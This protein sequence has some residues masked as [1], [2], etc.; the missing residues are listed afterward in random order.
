MKLFEIRVP[1]RLADVF[2]HACAREHERQFAELVGLVYLFV[3]VGDDRTVQN[4]RD[5]GMK[6]VVKP[7]RGNLE[8]LF[9]VDAVIERDGRFTT[10][11]RDAD[12]LRFVW[13]LLD[14]SVAQ[15]TVGAIDKRP[16]RCHVEYIFAPRD[17]FAATCLSP[18]LDWTIPGTFMMGNGHAHIL[19]P[20]GTNEKNKTGNFSNACSPGFPSRNRVTRWQSPS[21]SSPLIPD[22][23]GNFKEYQLPIRNRARVA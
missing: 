8:R 19:K 12:L 18:R 17:T 14:G 13:I 2:Y 20:M 6:R 9:A 5:D 11:L 23:D 4:A 3:R 10:S 16:R 7:F 1:N 15:Q 21:V 22:G